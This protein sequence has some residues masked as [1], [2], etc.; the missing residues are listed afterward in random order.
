MATAPHRRD[1]NWPPVRARSRWLTVAIRGIVVWP[2]VEYFQ[3]YDGFEFILLPETTR[4]PPAV[5]IELVPPLTL[6]T[7][8]AALRRFL[9]AYAWAEG[10][11]IDDD[12]GIGA[13]YPGGVGK[14][15][16]P[17]R[18]TGKNFHLAYLPSTTD[19]KA[20]LCLAL[21]REALGLNNPAY[22]F[23]A[24]FKIINV[25]HKTGPKQ[26]AWINAALPQLTDHTALSCLKE[27]RQKQ[28]DLGRYLYESGRCAVAHA[29]AQPIADPDD[30]AETE[31]L[32]SELPIVRAVAEHLIE[33]CLGV[34][35]SDT[36]RAEHLYELAG[37][38]RHFGEEICSRLKAKAA[39]TL[40]EMPALPRLDFNARH[41][42]VRR[43]FLG[44][45]STVVSVRD[46]A[47][48]VLCRSADQLTSLQLELDFHAERLRIDPFNGLATSDDGTPAGVLAAL[49][50]HR[51][52][53]QIFGNLVVEV[54]AENELELWGETA[55]YIPVNM[56]AN[57]QAWQESDAALFREY[58]LRFSQRPA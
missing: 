53:R 17:V 36:V 18:T 32:Q 25:L 14:P 9:S 48:I 15:E 38:R 1:R 44:M 12:F 10:H 29:Y 13:G 22:S 26:I 4:T 2:E 30:P 45:T 11:A 34:K 55:P 3:E 5:A 33:F 23:L 21:Y 7:A 42:I 54:R 24:F 41:R 47:V 20:R 49:D 50:T 51:F 6:R 43:P 58:L 8:R 35:S 40:A 28:P 19:P 27:L 52:F 56:R 37:F 39:V 16:G 31:R 57:A 46:G